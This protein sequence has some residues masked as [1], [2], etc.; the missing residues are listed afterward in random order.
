[1]EQAEFLN[2]VIPIVIALFTAAGANGDGGDDDGDH[3][4]GDENDNSHQLP[5]RLGGFWGTWNTALD[6]MCMGKAGNQE[7]C[8]YGNNIAFKPLAIQL[9]R[10][11][12]TRFA[13]GYEN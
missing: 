11:P 6:H 10:V 2:S 4:N 7:S 5:A 9:H 12:A 1:M 13:H 8:L 3:G